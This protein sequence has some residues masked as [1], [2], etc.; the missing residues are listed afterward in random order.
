[1]RKER[2][3]VEMQGTVQI[4][5]APAPFTW[6]DKEHVS[7]CPQLY[8]P[9]TWYLGAMSIF[10]PAGVLREDEFMEVRMFKESR[11]KD[12]NRFSCTLTAEAL[13]FE[14]GMSRRDSVPWPG[15]SCLWT[16]RSLVFW[17]ARR[18][19]DAAPC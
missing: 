2:I 16:V 1:M 19:Q 12:M 10:K 5:K 13:G 15:V 8:Q 7:W 18:S 17:K 3:A 4:S 14:A 11:E 9:S 6:R